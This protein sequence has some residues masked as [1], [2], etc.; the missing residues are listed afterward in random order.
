MKGS[1]DSFPSSNVLFGAQGLDS[2][3]FKVTKAP[4]TGVTVT[5][6][7]N[8]RIAYTSNSRPSSRKKTSRTCKLCGSQA[9]IGSY[10]LHFEKCKAKLEAERR[11][12]KVPTV[13]ST[14]RE[15]RRF[16]SLKEL[17]IDTKITA[18]RRKST[19]IQ[20]IEKRASPMK[21]LPSGYSQS[22]SGP[23]T[24]VCDLCGYTVL[25]H[26]F[27]N[28]VEKCKVKQ[29]A[30]IEEPSL[31]RLNSTMTRSMKQ[32]VE[33]RGLDIDV[34]NGEK[35]KVLEDIE[36][37]L[38]PYSQKHFSNPCIK[39]DICHRQ[40]LKHGFQMHKEKCRNL[41]EALMKSELLTK[42][43]TAPMT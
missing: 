5:F 24:K 20:E 11:D 2:D 7:P 21:R 37:A 26:G 31:P 22:S 8:G 9:L 23:N 41:I 40:V 15:I 16:V 3:L 33:S 30:L 36:S 43:L 10:G 32:F 29:Q 4:R 19:I 27:Q 42:P 18:D 6:G 34:T 14:L 38:V 17:K 35:D 13:D 39:C 1:T 12:L 28:H 25:V